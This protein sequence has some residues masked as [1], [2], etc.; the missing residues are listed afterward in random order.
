MTAP[1]I[2]SRRSFHASIDSRTDGQHVPHAVHMRELRKSHRHV[3]TADVDV[4]SLYDHYSRPDEEEDDESASHS[5][6]SEFIGEIVGTSETLPEPRISLA[7]TRDSL[8]QNLIYLLSYHSHR[9]PPLPLL[10]RYHNSHIPP[11][12]STRSYNLLIALSIRHASFGTAQQLF[13]EMRRE[14]VYM[15]DVTSKLR[16]RWL[17]QAGWWSA[18]WKEIA[19]RDLGLRSWPVPGKKYHSGS[20]EG[21]PLSI[22]LELLGSMRRG[23]IRKPLWR[24]K[25]RMNAWG[26]MVK[27]PPM[28]IVKET[29]DPAGLYSRRFKALMNRPP[30]LTPR[31]VSQ[32]PPR[33][34]FFIVG[35][36]LRYVD[37]DSA[38]AIAVSYF[39]H[40]PQFLGN[41]QCKTCMDIIHLLITFGS[42]KKRLAKFWDNRRNLKMLLAL[43]SKF[44]PT[45]TTL[46]LL[47]RSLSHTKH[48]GTQAYQLF[49]T[50]VHKW[51]PRVEDRR[52]RRR[53]VA[54]AL[55]ENQPRIVRDMLEREN[56]WRDY[57]KDW[58]VEREARG[59]LE[60]PLPPE[61][62]QAPYREVFKKVGRERRLWRGVRWKVR[63]YQ[64]LPQNAHLFGNKSDFYG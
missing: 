28:K 56:Y 45:S 58:V 51:G 52:V 33:A 16:M 27:S 13:A 12:R 2:L 3:S 8:Y 21:L 24:R 18:A 61:L 19:N 64:Q 23:A 7:K 55:K 37:K 41:K 25:K 39:Q 49:R 60:R 62:V 31:D 15:N 38:M 42:S 30:M 14:H 20:G 26:E 47:L 43:H 1:Q 50:F 29:N 34:I 4:E 40:L 32:T 17:V 11:L 22:W 46:L 53:I 44:R 9:A 48:C 6:K 57:R 54:L 63:R 35:M 59:G 36:L 5:G 10:I